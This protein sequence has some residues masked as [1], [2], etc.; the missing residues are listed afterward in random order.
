LD[1]LP[2]GEG[3]FL[4]PRKIKDH[5]EKKKIPTVV[6]KPKPSLRNS[7]NETL[8]QVTLEEVTRHNHNRKGEG[9]EPESHSS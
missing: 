3:S 2:I 6:T 5:R 8:S 1:L 4:P 7:I 9:L